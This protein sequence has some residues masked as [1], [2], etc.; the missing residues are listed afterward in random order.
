PSSRLTETT[1]GVSVELARLTLTILPGCRCRYD[2]AAGP[3]RTRPLRVA[4]SIGSAER[5]SSLG[6][7]LNQLCS[8]FALNSFNRLGRASKLA[9]LSPQSAVAGEL[10]AQSCE[11][12]VVGERAAGVRV[13]RVGR[14]ALSGGLG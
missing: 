8:R 5:A 7:R 3:S 12:S 6:S 9:R 4:T 14:G 2:E 10:L 13:A 11:R 1:F